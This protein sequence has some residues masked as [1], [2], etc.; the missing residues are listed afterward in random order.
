MLT[1]ELPPEA[2]ALAEQLLR[3][4]Y[5]DDCIVVFDALLK[6][7]RKSTYV[8]FSPLHLSKSLFFYIIL[9]FLVKL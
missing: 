8:S 2:T 5:D 3:A 7:D 1:P 9:F 6:E 4:F